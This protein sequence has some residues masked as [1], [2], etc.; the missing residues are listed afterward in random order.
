VFAVFKLIRCSHATLQ[1]TTGL[2]VLSEADTNSRNDDYVHFR[3][4]SLLDLA[5]MG[6]LELFSATLKAF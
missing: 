5:P 2:P 1:F 4:A 6:F 3:A